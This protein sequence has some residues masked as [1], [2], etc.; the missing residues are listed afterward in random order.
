MTLSAVAGSAPNLSPTL[1]AIPSPPSFKT[2][3]PKIVASTMTYAP[4][5][6]SPPVALIQKQ[7]KT[8][9]PGPSFSAHTP[10][11]VTFSPPS[12]AKIYPT[13]S[14]TTKPSVSISTVHP[15]PPHPP[16]YITRKTSFFS[17]TA[18]APPLAPS[19]LK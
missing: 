7:T 19:S 16:S 3:N 4:A 8:S 1:P 11:M 12:S 9:P 13:R 15:S 14:S 5:I 10:S 6:S 17:R 18:S 2:G